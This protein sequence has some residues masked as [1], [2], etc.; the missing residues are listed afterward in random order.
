[1]GLQLLAS[2]AATDTA[3]LAIAQAAHDVATQAVAD[4]KAADE[5]AANARQMVLSRDTKLNTAAANATTAIDQYATLEQLATSYAQALPASVADR[6]ALHDSLT[7]LAQRVDQIA[8]TPGPV[9]ATGATGDAGPQGLRGPSGVDGVQ[10]PPGAKGATGTTGAAGAAGVVGPT[11]AA[12]AQGATGPTG[13]TGPSGTANLAIGSRPVSLLALGGNTT[14]V[15]P[16]S[17]TMPDLTYRVEMAHSAVVS[18]ASGMLT[19]TART[20]SNVT[21]KVTAVGVALAAGTLVV[22]AV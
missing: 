21:I 6:Q 3:A 4:A 10:G 7:A 22:V 2:T 20:T 17:H 5:K 12:G 9:G 16:L 19:E 14:V 8:L 1:M 18:L 11:G 13:A 15:V